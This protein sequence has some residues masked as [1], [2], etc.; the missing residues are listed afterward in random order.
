[1]LSARLLIMDYTN[2]NNLIAGFNKANKVSSWKNQTQLYRVNLLKETYYLQ[3][4]LRSHTYKQSKETGFRICEQGHLRL[5]KAL[6]IRDTVMQQSLVNTVLIPKLTPY[7]IH[8]NGAS[9]KGKG[10]SF[11]RRRFEQHLAWHYRRYGVD[12]YV[13]KVDF[14][15]YFDNISHDVLKQVL[16]NY[17]GDKEVM[18]V[19][20][21]ILKANEQDISYT[22][23][24]F[25]DEPFDALKHADVDPSEL[26]GKRYLKR[27][28][29]IGSTVSQIAG[30]FLPTRIDNWCKTVRQVH[31][32][33]AY[34]DD[35]III[36]HDK[37]FL[38]KLLAEITAIAKSLGIFIH[39][40]KTQIIKLSH[41]FTFLKTRYQ[42]TK[43]GRIIRK[44]PKDVLKREHR[45]LNKLAIL[46][47][48]GELTVKQYK[49][50]YRSW[51]GDKKRYNAYHTLKRMD[52][53]FRR[54]LK[55][56]TKNKPLSPQNS[57]K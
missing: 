2:A 18:W 41:G 16:A 32:Y 3:R 52:N 29:G 35:R 39:S 45:K 57:R 36:H 24:D 56:I 20:G 7:M 10:I 42:L 54:K 37:A 9:L 8:D 17:I 53:L 22:D 43:T 49:D 51:R 26:T 31:C 11:T 6:K 44:I 55:W 47:V 5:I 12:G 46:V 21:E 30:I 14:R 15:K 33:D 48:V 34:M 40:D 25:S 4:E 28:L 23:K 50:Q 38:R 1:M 13:L 19:L 27:S